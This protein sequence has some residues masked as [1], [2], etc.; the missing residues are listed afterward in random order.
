MSEEVEPTSGSAQSQSLRALLLDAD[1]FFAVKVADTL[2]HVGYTTR[3]VRRLDAFTAALEAN[4]PLV[5]LVNSAAPTVDWRAAIRAAH[6]VGVAI[7]AYGSHVDVEAQQQARDAG[8]TAVIANSKLAQDLP[9][10]V[11]RALRR[12][13]AAPRDT[14]A[15]DADT[16][17]DSP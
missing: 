7:I 9:A 17:D 8:A 13:E 2:K 15:E 14:T 5:A 10:V 12:N 1:L 6:A 11:A 3:T 16:S 4:P